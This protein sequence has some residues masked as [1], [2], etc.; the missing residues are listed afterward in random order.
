MGFSTNVP[1]IKEQCVYSDNERYKIGDRVRVLMKSRSEEYIGKIIS[2]SCEA[3][4]VQISYGFS[5]FE[6]KQIFVSEV[7]KMRIAEPKESFNDSFFFDEEEKEFWRTHIIGKEGIRER[8][9]SEKVD[10]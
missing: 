8:T 4:Y 9:G 2:I 7:G 1:S 5:D 3:F 10:W 6:N